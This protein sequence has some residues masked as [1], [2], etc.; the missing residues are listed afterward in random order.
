MKLLYAN[1]QACANQLLVSMLVSCIP[2][3]CVNQCHLGCKRD[4]ST[5]LEARDSQL[6]KTNP[7]P[8]RIWFCRIFNKVD[9]S[10]KLRVLL[11]LV[12]KRKL[13]ASM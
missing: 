12:D 8:L 9:Q 4:G 2:T 5:I 13:I 7:A 11:Q 1:H 3:Q 6:A 10:V